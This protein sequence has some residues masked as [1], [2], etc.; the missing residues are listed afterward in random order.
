VR[1][2]GGASVVQ[3]RPYSVS[4]HILPHSQG[5]LKP[6]AQ[7]I[8]PSLRHI[9]PPP[10]G[11][12]HA[13]KVLPATH[14]PN[15]WA[16]GSSSAGHEHSG[17][18][19]S[20]SSHNPV[21]KS[22]DDESQDVEPQ[23]PPSHATSASNVPA[24]LVP[25]VPAVPAVPA[26]LAPGSSRLQDDHEQKPSKP[27]LARSVKRAISNLRKMALSRRLRMD[28]ATPFGQNAR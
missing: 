21:S 8:A 20:A 23:P 6:C 27:E 14:W 22:A 11:A 7:A 15:G 9:A 17:R 5:W 3:L 1:Q 12:L 26:E 18:L 10:F 19:E 13:T 28:A 4:S 16:S 25:P 2:P 24:S